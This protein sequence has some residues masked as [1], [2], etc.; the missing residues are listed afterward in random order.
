MGVKEYDGLV[1]LR[2][3]AE[4]AQLAKQPIWGFGWH[5]SS[6]RDRYAFWHAH[7][8]G[9][10]A[11][12]RESCAAELEAN[13]AFQPVYKL[14][15]LLQ[16][17]ILAG[18]EP[19]RVY[20]NLHTFGH[21]GYPHRDSPDRENYWTTVY[22]AHEEW[23]SAWGGELAFLNDTYDEIIHSTFPRPGRLVQFSGSTPHCAR[24][25]SRECSKAR[26]T[27]VIKTQ[28]KRSHG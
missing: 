27:V 12:S 17:N 28:K 6:A 8:A 7:G 13:V 15:K 5:S 26:V 3:Q 10:D 9:G 11:K 21:E 18:H 20:A 1:P 14:F 23:H 2:L 22:F 19:L 4:L 16:K 25:V 24:G